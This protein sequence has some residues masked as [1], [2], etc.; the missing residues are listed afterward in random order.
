MAGLHREGA[1]AILAARSR[2]QRDAMPTSRTER[3]TP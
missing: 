2:E 3:A 1:A